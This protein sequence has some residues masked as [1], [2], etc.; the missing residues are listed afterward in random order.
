M[1][2]CHV[3]FALAAGKGRKKESGGESR[4]ISGKA[5]KKAVANAATIQPHG[6]P[7]ITLFLLQ[8]I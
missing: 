3:R 2:Q 4:L 5:G 7:E 1:N 8:P 6:C